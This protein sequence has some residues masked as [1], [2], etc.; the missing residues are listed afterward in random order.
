MLSNQALQIYILLN[1]CIRKK[2]TETNDFL[3]EEREK[4]DRPLSSCQQVLKKAKWPTLEVAIK[5]IIRAYNGF[6]E[7]LT[8][9]W[10]GYAWLVDEKK[11][12]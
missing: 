12:Y 5:P 2:K 10:S 11:V 3:R 9:R 7:C 8:G 1:I 4:A 6:G